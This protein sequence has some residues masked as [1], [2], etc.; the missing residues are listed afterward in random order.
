MDHTEAGTFAPPLPDEPGADDDF[1]LGFALG[2][3]DEDDSNPFADAALQMRDTEPRGA[4]NFD[5]PDDD[6]SGGGSGDSMLPHG[7]EGTLYA[8]PSGGRVSLD[9]FGSGKALPD[10]WEQPPMPDNLPSEQASFNPPTVSEPVPEPP[11]GGS[12]SAIPDDWDLEGDETFAPQAEMPTPP[13]ARPSSQAAPPPT[14]PLPPPPATGSQSSP[15][16]DPPPTGQQ[17]PAATPQPAS[18][19]GLS[20]AAALRAFLNG[21]GLG[22]MRLSEGE[23]VTLLTEA[24]RVF[25]AAIAGLQEALATRA[26]IKEELHVD[27]TMIGATSNNPLKLNLTVDEGVVA[28]LKRP[29][30]GFLAPVEAV[31]QGFQD[32]QAHQMATMAAMHLALRRL[33][34]KF[35]PQAL[36]G[37]LEQSSLMNSLMPGARKSKYWEVYCDFYKSIAGDAESEFHEFFTREFSKAY[38]EQ[39]RKLK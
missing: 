30:H 31:E 35:D 19:G 2:D 15:F 23:A 11:S 28:M 38:E 32:V 25:R 36:Q 24:G 22:S 18:G 6:Y 10:D 29:G 16:F 26:E 5:M 20:D 39:S 13:P 7:P 33:L 37:R 12:D 4:P 14:P 21:V 9:P 17:R 27:R 8:K 1:D 34:G 3:E